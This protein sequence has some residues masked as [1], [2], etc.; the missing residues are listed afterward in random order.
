MASRKVSQLCLDLVLVFLV[1]LV[2]PLSGADVDF[3]L[4]EQKPAGS[5]V[6]NISESSGIIK[7]ISKKDLPFIRYSF[8]N[9]NT[10]L[11]ASMFSIN[12]R[13]GAVFSTA[14]IDREEVCN[15]SLTCDIVF[16]VT[17]QLN[18]TLLRILTVKVTIDDVNDN[19][20]VFRPSEI[21]TSIVESDTIGRK[22]P[23]HGATDSDTGVNNSVK[24]YAIISY[25]D[26]FDI[27]YE[28]KLD[29]RTDLKIFTLGPL[30]REIK[31]KYTLKIIATDGGSEQKTGTLTVHIDVTDFNDHS[32]EFNQKEYNLFVD[33]TRPIGSAVGQI[34]AFDKDIGQNADVT[35]SFSSIRPSQLEDLFDL[36]FTTGVLTVKA[37]LAY[38]SGKTYKTVIE[39]RDDGEPSLASQAI[40]YATILDVGNTPPK[41]ELVLKSPVY[42]DTILLS[43]ESREGTFVGHVK[44]EDFD[45][46]LNGDVSCESNDDRFKVEEL[47]G[48][49]YA[50]LINQAL[51]RELHDQHNVT[52]TC[53]DSGSPSMSAFV[54][55][56]AIITDVNDSPPVFSKPVYYAN[57]SE[58]SYL[59]KFV[60]Q[61]SASDKDLGV[62]GDVVYKLNLDAGSM[63]SIDENSGV[64]TAN[65]VF[66][67]EIMSEISF[68][69]K[70][71]DQGNEALTGTATVTVNILDVNDN[72]PTFPSTPVM[73]YIPEM[74]PAGRRVGKIEARD[75]DVGLNGE[76]EYKL[77]TKDP[78]L[79]FNVFTDGV[80][81]TNRLVIR[82]K[83]AVYNLS[84]FVLDKG[85]PSLNATG[86][87][88]ITVQDINNHRPR[89]IFPDK[90]KDTI[91]IFSDIVPGSNI[92]KVIATDRD[93]GMNAQLS[94]FLLS[95]N[96]D[97]LFKMIQ[98][99]GEILLNRRI[100]VSD[101]SKYDLRIVVKDGGNPS[102]QSKGRLSINIIFTNSTLLAANMEAESQRYMIIAG[103]VAG[104]TVVISVVILST[105]LFIRRTDPS[106][107]QHQE[108][109]EVD[110]G[111][112]PGPENKIWQEVDCNDSNVGFSEDV[113]GFSPKSSPK[114]KRGL[115]LDMDDHMTDILNQATLDH[116]GRQDFYTFR[117]AHTLNED[118]RSDMSGETTTSDSGRGGS[119][120]DIHFTQCSEIPEFRV[121]PHVYSVGV[122]GAYRES[123]PR[124][125]PR[126][127]R[128]MSVKTFK[129]FADSTRQFTP[130][131]SSQSFRETL[132]NG[133][134]DHN[135]IN[136]SLRDLPNNGYKDSNIASQSLRETL[137][138]GFQ[139]ITRE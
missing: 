128:A 28:K 99:S 33:E 62:N 72:S 40:L 29:G 20:P 102:R 46:G 49:G 56:L 60:T 95:G 16:D 75:L 120:D 89:I 131:P 82:E 11:T 59:K 80:I 47:E 113:D 111:T 86:T 30:D 13:S 55:F 121:S 10:L 88:Q 41:L 73:L 27:E 115:N 97:N 34:E 19:A 12:R 104:I 32:P 87:V 132:N 45:T 134:K 36:D 61:V 133:Y 98:D 5:Y 2:V 116:Y 106:R 67:R 93:E 23:V 84:I 18:I 137:N 35:Y 127:R 54:N 123:P 64:V 83:Q 37:P 114:D 53:S 8:L 109:T 66:D 91:T 70:A 118:V 9:P 1:R 24:T 101:E 81:R 6:G 51:D 39:A 76:L 117:N 100:T 112:K 7:G 74:L 94:Y 90:D 105:I 26:L 129:T 135:I 52:I 63:F 3:H 31:N 50:I 68:I 4:L 78:D 126:E 108:K 130:A 21:T 77:L 125:P 119:E 69:V 107:R 124:I 17:V 71:V 25:Q 57:L 92:T 58:N 43:E 96:T 79:P 138:N 48:K 14:M 42:T 110:S 122:D 136:Q 38:H 44:V 103:V 85:K 139:T 15:M 65:D 22:I